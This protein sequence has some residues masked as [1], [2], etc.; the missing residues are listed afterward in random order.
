MKHLMASPPAGWKFFRGAVRGT[1]LPLLT[2][3][4]VSAQA[5]N[6]P[7]GTTWDCILSGS[8]QQGI[9]FLS[10]ADDYTFTGYTTFAGKPRK[11]RNPDE[12]GRLGVPIFRGE[13]DPDEKPQTY[14]YGF[15]PISG[16]WSYDTRGRVIGF[17][18]VVVNVTAVETNYLQHC[19][20]Y[21]V[22]VFGDGAFTTNLS[23]CFSEASYTTNLV[24][25]SPSNVQ[26]T[27]TFENPNFT[28]DIAEAETTNSFSFKAKVVPGK[29]LS[30]SATTTVGKINF[31]GVPSTPLPDR[32]GSN[33]YGVKKADGQTFLEF[34]TLTGSTETNIYFMDGSGPAYTY[35]NGACMISVQKKIAMAVS[36]NGDNLRSTYGPL[37]INFT[38]TTARTRGGQLRESVEMDPAVSFDVTLQPPLP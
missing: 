25:T 14:L 10:F 8:G 9:A 11:A 4:A 28:V 24:W 27:L 15:V 33:W 37:R 20:N 30:L 18:S 23:F 19:T 29:R 5:Q 2:A 38:T 32:D 7:V 26:Q 16:P 13:Q 31:K 34:F 1:L 17:F 21:F 12:E 35:T 6:S 36:E 22:D 3:L